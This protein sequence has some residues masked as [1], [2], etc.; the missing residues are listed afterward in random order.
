MLS[1]LFSRSTKPRPF[2]KSKKSITKA[3]S[4]QKPSS[5]LFNIL[6]AISDAQGETQ[7]ATEALKT[8]FNLDPSNY[9]I[10]LNLAK[11][12]QSSGDLDG[13]LTYFEKATALQANEIEPLLS[14]G[15]V[16]YLKGNISEALELFMR[17]TLLDANNPSGYFGVADC[18]QDIKFTNHIPNLYAV[19]HKILSEG[20]YIR[21]SKIATA[22]VSV[23]KQEPGFAEILAKF[24]MGDEPIS[25]DELIYSCNATKT[26]KKL[27]EV[28]NIPDIAIE[29]LLR[30]CRA[31]LL[32]GLA[33]FEKTDELLTFIQS[34]SLHCF[35]NEY[36]YPETSEESI[37]IDILERQV[38]DE[39]ANSKT[40][41][42]FEIAILSCYRPL[43][44]YSWSTAISLPPRLKK[45]HRIHIQ[46]PAR[47]RKLS[48]S[49]GCLGD[50]GDEISQKI[51]KQ[52]EDNPYPRWTSTLVTPSKSSLPAFVK[53]NGYK[54]DLEILNKSKDIQTL[55]A[56]CGTGQQILGSIGAYQSSKILALDL[57][58]SSLA[59]AK[60]KTDELS[61]RHIEFLR[62][63]IIDLSRIERQ[64]DVIECTGVLHHMS[65]PISGWAAIC[66]CLRNGGLMKIGLYSSIARKDISS[67]RQEIGQLGLD[68]TADNMRLYRNHLINSDAEQH[69]RIKNIGDFYSLS[70]FRDLLFNLHEEHFTIPRIRTN[71]A[72]LGLE[73][74]GMVNWQTL[75]RRASR[76]PSGKTDHHD[77]D[78][79]HDFEMMNPSAFLGMYQFW[80]QK[81]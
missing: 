51:Q 40:L 5:H 44:C 30:Y 3:I 58:I 15:R 39:I 59:Y 76:L 56:G 77:L 32:M 22:T 57:S 55:I 38:D 71:L 18:L 6:G 24:A 23:I 61:L 37:L 72:E 67:M 25:V 65:D 31:V 75:I 62:A 10:T 1:L 63:D 2:A 70:N 33:E 53:S 13:A 54:V 8:A 73:F 7:L 34:L 74:C 27:M 17:C 21:A 16:N 29:N 50:P 14:L 81:S 28:A 42:P 43:S 78:W 11:L 80:C 60:R 41:N 48:L 79:W 49:I 69:Q 12:L 26:L 9:A 36:I 47:E 46:E 19:I 64:F 20:F 66:D 68:P 45:L 52:Y 35:G 4:L